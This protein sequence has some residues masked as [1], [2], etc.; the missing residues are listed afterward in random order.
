MD[1]VT[2]RITLDTHKG[3]VQKTLY[4][5]FAG[6]VL[7]R[8]IAISLVGGSTPC[9]YDEVTAAVMY[10]T[11]PNG[12]TSY[13]ACTVEENVIFYDVL[14][15]DTDTD[16]IVTMQFKVMSGETVL[17]APEFALEVQESKNG[18]T[19]AEE[20]PTY[21][22]LEEA[23]LKTEMVASNEQ[24]RVD[25]EEKRA[26]EYATMRQE[27]Q[28]IIEEADALLAAGGISE[29]KAQRMID[30]A[31]KGKVDKVE[32]QGLSTNDYSDEEKQQVADNKTD[33]EDLKNGAT[34]AGN[35]L[36][37][38]GLTAEEFVSNPN[39][40]INT[41]FKNPVNSS[42]KTSWTSTGTT[43]DR[44]SISTANATAEIT[45]GGLAV[46]FSSTIYGSAI[47]QT[48]PYDL[49]SLAGKTFAVSAKIDGV[50]YSGIITLPD[51]L[52]GVT[53]DTTNVNCGVGVYMDMIKSE[54]STAMLFRIVMGVEKTITIEWIKLEPGSVAT[55]FVPPNPEVEKLKCLGADSFA[56]GISP[57]FQ[58]GETI[59]D[60]ANNPNGVY[61]KF[62]IAS[63]G[64]PSD[65][66]KT[67]EGWCELLIDKEKNRKIVRYTQ[68]GSDDTIITYKRSIW[69]NAWRGDGWTKGNDGG[70]AD[71]VDGYE[72]SVFSRHLGYTALE[73]VNACGMTPY[74]CMIGGDVA[75]TIGLPTA[76]YRIQYI[77]DQGEGY[78]TQIAYGGTIDA[79]YFRR[80][81]VNV[82]GGWSS[83]FLPLDGS[84]PMIG[85]LRIQNGYG[86]VGAD[87]NHASLIA[88]NV[89]SDNSN[90]RALMV[91]NTQYRAD[92]S[93]CL[94]IW[95]RTNG[96]VTVETVLHTGNSN[97]V[98]VAATAPT[99]TTALW[100]DTANKVIKAYI[101]GAW[102]V[103]GGGLTG[104]VVDTNPG[105]GASVS[106]ADGTL[107]FT[108]E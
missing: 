55:P 42:G 105:V 23:L 13:N 71:T 12:N 107:L 29:E 106:Y 27:M 37:L 92:D 47:M 78:G 14:Q 89:A 25:A 57:Y 86:T 19:P 41:D 51:T 3:G 11:K 34:P 101:D 48:L 21:T 60:W 96:A 88:N 35:S 9:K 30:E 17:Y 18:D 64:Y 95:K 81:N 15:A 93:A 87:G 94:E 68:F 79:V 74:T 98:T 49:E 28:E 44:W 38:N 20:T 72:A 33:I 6:D 22:A 2:Y 97:A 66:P 80:A 82:W 40:L 32:G 53:V 108:K 77:P 10:V 39:L 91:Y 73:T 62:I 75:N 26:E 54:S 46:T 8:R 50:V 61:K 4:G 52:D 63:N 5:F 70:N 103:V 43:V 102:T 7:A 67:A 56:Q 83:L 99:D 69:N 31:T 76:T 85:A 24:E 59:L 84:V 104:V 90:S 16:G 58:S 1:K 36:K 65:A 100:V 45:E